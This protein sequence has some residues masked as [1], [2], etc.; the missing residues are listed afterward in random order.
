AVA[1]VSDAGGNVARPTPLVGRDN[2][3]ISAFG[4]GGI[5][6]GIDP[7][8]GNDRLNPLKLVSG[9]WP[10]N[11]SEIA[12]DTH[13]AS[14]KHYSLGQQIGATIGDKLAHYRIAG[15]VKLGQASIGGTPLAVFDLATG[16]KLFQK[17]GE[18]DAIDVSSKAGV[19]PQQLVDQIKPILPATAEVRTGTAQAAKDTSDTSQFTT[20]I[21]DF[22]LAFAGIA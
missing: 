4:G 15:I 19:T 8:R 12:I 3:V 16:Q 7:R 2:K 22:L 11:G 13:T 6:F 20:I 18:L 21:Q 17:E 14:S 5:G 1:G 9:H 10:T